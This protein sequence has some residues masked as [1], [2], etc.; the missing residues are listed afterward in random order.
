MSKIALITGAAGVLGSEIA[1]AMLKN[2]YSVILLDVDQRALEQLTKSLKNDLVGGEFITIPCNLASEE[3]I[4]KVAKQV[5]DKFGKIHVLV[6]NAATKTA[7]IE[8]FFEPLENFQL[9]TWNEILG[10]NLTSPFLMAKHFGSLIGDDEFAGA[11]IQISS[12]YGVIAPDQ[13][14]YD[15]AEYMNTAINSPAVYSATKAGVIGLSRYLAAYWGKRNITSNTI[16]PGG[17]YSGQNEIF[18]KNYNDR[19]PL[20]RM[21]SAPDVCNAVLFLCS[22]NAR[23][24]TGQNI[25]VDGGLSSW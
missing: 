10:V 8:N 12:I 25:I 14:I 22:E 2:N 13:R 7:K 4:S 15:G 5:Y 24:I 23:Y 19:V 3:S 1:R 9:E 17:V 11:V 16:S 18:E 20:G 21:A 6:N